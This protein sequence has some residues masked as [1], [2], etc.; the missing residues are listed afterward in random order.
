MWYLRFPSIKW[1]NS[2]YT[3]FKTIYKYNKTASLPPFPLYQIQLL[4]ML[5]LG[6]VDRRKEITITMESKNERER[7]EKRRRGN[8]ILKSG[9][10]RSGDRREEITSIFMEQVEK[11]KPEIKE[12]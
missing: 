4:H 9:N 3:R 8:R 7:E 1:E 5:A 12:R 2:K 10:G 6:N 11:R